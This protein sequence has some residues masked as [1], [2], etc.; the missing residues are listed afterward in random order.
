M[1]AAFQ[2][3]AHRRVFKKEESWDSYEQIIHIFTFWIRLAEFDFTRPQNTL[4]PVHRCSPQCSYF[5]SKIT[6][7]ISAIEKN[8]NCN[9]VKSIKFMAK[10]VITMSKLGMVK[11][12]TCENE[13]KLEKKIFDYK[14]DRVY[15]KIC[16]QYKVHNNR[17]H[18]PDASRK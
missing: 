15:K 6:W 12:I 8:W 18:S 9:T 2:R 13:S 1:A 16:C 17:I 10:I 7:I 14:L 3:A 4:L 11:D 5:L